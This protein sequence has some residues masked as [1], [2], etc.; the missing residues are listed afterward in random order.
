[1]DEDP[2]LVEGTCGLQEGVSM[3]WGLQSGP[4]SVAH[5]EK[6]GVE[7]PTLGQVKK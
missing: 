6:V 4:G 5:G 7:V 2:Q 1:M 3:A